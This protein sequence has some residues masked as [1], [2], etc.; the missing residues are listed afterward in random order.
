MSVLTFASKK[1][2][3]VGKGRPSGQIDW[4]RLSCGHVRKGG[5]FAWEYCGETPRT[6]MRCKG[7]CYRDTAHEIV[8]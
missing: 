5:P 8:R 7:D 3:Q 1:I 6:I 4:R 2:E